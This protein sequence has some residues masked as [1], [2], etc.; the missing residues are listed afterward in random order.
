M[1]TLYAL[2]PIR[3]SSFVFFILTVLVQFEL[4]GVRS[5]WCIIEEDLLSLSFVLLE[6]LDMRYWY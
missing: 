6:E 3:E 1:D 2:E 5:D 4:R